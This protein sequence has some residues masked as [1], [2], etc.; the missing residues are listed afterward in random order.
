MKKLIFLFALLCVTLASVGQ[1]RWDGFF[2]PVPKDMFSTNRAVSSQW[3]FRPTVTVTSLTFK[4]K[5]TDGKFDGIQ[6]A[7]L[8]KAGAGLTFAHY[9]EVDGLPY[10]NFSVNGILLLPT[11]NAL[12]VVTEEN[13]SVALAV[14]VSA[15]QYINVGLGYDII[16]GVPIAQ[17][18]FLLTGV[19]L[20]F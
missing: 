7:F 8:S 17:N 15:L 2:K 1:S 13:S 10:N 16:K 12:G 4:I 3:L 18:F 6:S 9:I 11:S 14:T 5:Q 20:T 19:Q